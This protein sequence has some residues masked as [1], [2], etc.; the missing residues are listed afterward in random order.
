MA[1][2]REQLLFELPGGGRALFTTR[3]DGN[4]STGAG[5][6]HVHGL[7]RR[8]E[9]CG[10]LGLR[11]LCSSRQVHGTAV[12]VVDQIT[13]AGGEPL[14]I[15]ADGH[16]TATLAVGATVLAADCLPV[17][18]GCA[19]AVAMLHAGWRGLAAGVLEQGVVTLR[20]LGSEEKPIVAV[21]GPGAGV[22]CYEVGGEVQDAFAGAHM[23]GRRLELRAV[24]EERLR[25]AGVTDVSHVN[26]CTICDERFFSY[27]REGAPAGRH[28]GIAWLS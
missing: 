20:T 21:V 23:H 13:G 16:A 8:A 15:D 1:D 11:W 10:R 28:A 7:D 14:A 6:D 27:R 4:L 12:H 22:C 3:A 24:A 9:L 2:Q 18:L 19:G 26:A 17:A 25:A 5:D